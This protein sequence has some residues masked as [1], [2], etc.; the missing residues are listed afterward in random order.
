MCVSAQK[1]HTIVTAI[2]FVLSALIEDTISKNRY[3]KSGV[4]Q[5]IPT[6]KLSKN[7]KR[8][9]LPSC[10]QPVRHHEIGRK[11]HS[12]LLYQLFTIGSL[13][14]VLHRILRRPP[15]DKVRTYAY[16]CHA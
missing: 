9:V 8:L 12:P 16:S 10:I 5:W 11:M 4:M 15:G 2:V 13:C 7:K 6:I 3:E 14:N 1:D